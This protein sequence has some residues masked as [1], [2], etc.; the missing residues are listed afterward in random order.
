MSKAIIPLLCL[1]MF[2]S[3]AKP[4]DPESLYNAGGYSVVGRLALAG[5]GEDVKVRDTIAYV[6]QGEG[7]LTIVSIADRANPRVLS[8]YHE[9]LRGAASKVALKDSIL[10][11]VEGTSG[12]DIVNVADP[13]AAYWCGHF[14]GSGTTSHD[15]EVFG[16]WM[17]HGLGGVGWQVIDFSYS[18]I[19]PDPQSTIEGPGFSMGMAMTADSS[20]LIACGEMGFAAY[21]L[22]DTTPS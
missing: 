15:V 14:G 12:V 20:L 13:Y 6:A 11:C 21:D 5:Y 3:C 16:Q 4:T 1:V 17:F 10:Y 2:L 8:S 18:P 19:V 22:R 9:R 7:N